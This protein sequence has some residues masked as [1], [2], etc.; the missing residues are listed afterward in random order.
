M[1]GIVFFKTGKLDE[2]KLFYTGRVGCEIWMDQ[3]DCVIFKHG[4][5]LLGFCQRDEVDTGGC[6][7]FFY[8]KREEVDKAYINFKDVAIDAPKLNEKYNI[9]NFFA[10]DPEGRTIEFQLFEND[11]NCYRQGDDLLLSRRSVRKFKDKPVPDELLN[12]VLDLSR[13]APTSMNTQGYYFK[14]IRDKETLEKLASTRGKSSEPIIRAPIAIAICVD[15]Q[16]TKRHIQDGCIAA[17]HFLLAAWYYGLGTCWIA[18]MD[19]D[20]IKEWLNIPH[21]HYVATVT[22]LGYP[23]HMN[24]NPP[25]RKELDWFLRD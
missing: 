17:Y 1:N 9:Y 10:R 21:D 6:I 4:N 3:N 25:E 5:M 13:W 7:T 14:I 15:P 20:D 2:I 8:E 22:P 19:R 23:V 11:V 18:A 16:I 12:K 24:F